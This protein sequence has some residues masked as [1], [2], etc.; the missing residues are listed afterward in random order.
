MRRILYIALIA[1]LS[2]CH[3]VEEWDNDPEG[4]FES[5]WSTIDSHYCFFKEKGVDWDEVYSRYRPLVNS[6]TSYLDLFTICS[7]M[8]DELQDGHVNLSSW[9]ATSYYKKWWSDYPQ[10]YD[11]RLVEQYYL[12]FNEY[13]RNGLSYYVL[14]DSVGYMRYPSFSYAPGETTL[15]WALALLYRCRGLIIDIRDNGGGALSNVETIVR[16]FI[17]QRITAGYITHKT[18]AGHDDFSEPYEFF[19]DP[20]DQGRVSWPTVDKPVVVLTNRSTFS[21][22]NNF[23]SIMRLQ[24]NVTL[25]GDRTGGGSGM[26][27]NSE[28]PCGWAL[29]F[30]ASPIYDANM[31]STEQGVEPSIYVDLDQ[32]LALQ[33]IDTMLERAI[34]FIVDATPNYKISE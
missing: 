14:S 10:N 4:N 3:N 18:G 27:F 23:A 17:N 20:A 33:G 12:N 13:T 15:D 25:I 28:L 29:R 22:A 1:L 19:Y 21:A 24:Y 32:E 16:R 31:Q 2:A 34:Q 8:L 26:P 30:S 9:F 7:D 11:E 6:E 5:L